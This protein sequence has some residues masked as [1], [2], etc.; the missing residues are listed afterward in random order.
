MVRLGPSELANAAAEQLKI[1]GNPITSIPALKE[2]VL[3]HQLGAGWTP[4]SLME[5]IAVIGRD[6]A[7]D[8]LME[9]MTRNPIS[10]IIGYGSRALAHAIAE[11]NTN[12]IEE[13][14]E[15][16]TLHIDRLRR[17][18]RKFHGVHHDIDDSRG[19]AH[20]LRLIRAGAHYGG[21]WHWD[22][23]QRSREL[24]REFWQ[25][26]RLRRRLGREFRRP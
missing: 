2:R 24:R 17:P 14:I 22:R 25:E 12:R 26:R 16:I 19:A 20:L 8:A 11:H 13:G 10:R 7:I 15:H 9:I 6:K 21:P 4:I 18:H 1:I 23:F 5:S 3:D